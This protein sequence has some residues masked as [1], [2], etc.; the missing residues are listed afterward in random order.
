MLDAW[1]LALETLVYNRPS[2][3][4]THAIQRVQAQVRVLAPVGSTGDLRR[5]YAFLRAT[6]LESSPRD[7][8][9]RGEVLSL[10][11]IEDAAFG[12]RY[13]ELVT[14]RHVDLATGQ[15]NLWMLATA[16]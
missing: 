15:L 10:R 6:S 4:R 11:Q 8:M 14:G 3:Q 1:K 12:V 7:T 16:G 2:P 13:L 9:R 5:H